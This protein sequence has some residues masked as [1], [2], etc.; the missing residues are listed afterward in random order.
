[1]T[2]TTIKVPAKVC[3]T[4][5]RVTTS[6]LYEMFCNACNYNGVKSVLVRTMVECDR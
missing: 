3:P 4:C 5:E 6:Y 1:M 2:T